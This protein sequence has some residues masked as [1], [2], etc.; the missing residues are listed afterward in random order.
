VVAAFVGF[1]I[2]KGE[3][4]LVLIAFGQKVFRQSPQSPQSWRFDGLLILMDAKINIYHS[5]ERRAY[6]KLG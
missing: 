3:A 4:E 1:E 2:A 6:G 5:S